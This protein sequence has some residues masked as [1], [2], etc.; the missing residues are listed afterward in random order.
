MSVIQEITQRNDIVQSYP[1]FLGWRSPQVD[2][3]GQV[4]LKTL[5]RAL[6]LQRLKNL[7][8]MENDQS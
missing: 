8:V 2:P 3:S 6:N 4:S 7:S 5:L 1:L